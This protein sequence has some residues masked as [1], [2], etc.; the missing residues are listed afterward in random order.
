MIRTAT[1][2][3]IPALV[4]MGGRFFAASGFADSTSYDPDSMAHTFA[5]LIESEQGVLL[6]ADGVGMA[7]ALVYP[8]YFNRH[9]LVAQEL[10]W[11]VDEDARK[12]G[13]GSRLLLAIEAWA[14]ERGAKSLIMLSLSALD[15]EKVNRMY[16]NAG[17]R[18]AEQSFIKR[19]D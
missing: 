6:V 7:G 18:P 17:Y 1:A 13:A 14:A 4:E 5:Q 12:S 2:A 3:D 16:E 11:W 10:F 8:H 9:D 15:A 19:L